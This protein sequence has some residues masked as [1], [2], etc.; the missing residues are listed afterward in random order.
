MTP[1]E[2]ETR[3]NPPVVAL[4][5]QGCHMSLLPQPCLSLLRPAL[6]WEHT[7]DK[8]MYLGDRLPHARGEHQ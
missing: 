4:I 8:E 1:M 2:N 5:L 6:L 3:L 7:L